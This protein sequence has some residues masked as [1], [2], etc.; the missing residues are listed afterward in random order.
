[1]DAIME[2]G[3][4]LILWL[5]GLGD[6]LVPPMTFMSFLGTEIFY[7]FIAPAIF[8]CYDARLGLRLGLALMV[9][10]ILNSLFKLLFHTPRPFWIDTRVQAP[11]PESSFGIP[12][13]HAQNAVVVWGVLANWFKGAWAWGIALALMFLIGFSRMVLG[14]HFLSDVLLGW[15]IG[16]LLLWAILACEKPLLNWLKRFNLTQQIGLAFTASLLVIALGFLVRMLIGDWSLP[17]EWVAN[18]VLADP[19][20][21]PINPLGISGLVSNAGAFFGLAAGGMWL[22][23]RGGFNAGGPALQRLL[24]F[25]LGLLGVMLIWGGLGQIFPDG[26]TFLPLLLRYLRYGLVG[27]WI[28]AL[29][30]RVF[31]RMRLAEG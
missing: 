9:T 10:G 24:R 17:P 8:W 12:S 6:W 18:A 5:Q 7:L 28:A 25:V 4:Q 19:G 13:G 1:M 16:A 27:L 15:L 20:G 29:A 21:E 11:H 31:V 14:V 2:L 26:E 3:I 23:S 30:P 22:F